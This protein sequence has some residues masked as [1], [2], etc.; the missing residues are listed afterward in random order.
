MSVSFGVTDAQR[1]EVL[2]AALRRAEQNK[3][4][5]LTVKG[6]KDKEIAD[7]ARARAEARSKLAAAHHHAPGAAHNHASGRARALGD[8]PEYPIN[9][10]DLHALRTQHAIDADEQQ[11]KK[12]VAYMR[13]QGWM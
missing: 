10:A 12:S 7:A 11:Q 8:S 13:A 9:M 3:S 6:K 1:E 2:A 5:L 4:K